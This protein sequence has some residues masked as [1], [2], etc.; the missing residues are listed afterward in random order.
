MS[1]FAGQPRRSLI[2]E[3]IQNSLDAKRE[4]AETVTVRFELNSC[5]RNMI[6]DVERLSKILERC[7][8]ASEDESDDSKE[9][10]ADASK[11]LSE[12][13]NFPVLTCTDFGTSGMEGPYKKSLLHI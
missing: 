1:T 10:V 11:F 5:A 2:R 4:N 6:P 12:R 9:S 13:M 8:A 3:L 7:V